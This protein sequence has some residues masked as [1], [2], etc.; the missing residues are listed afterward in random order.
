MELA[1]VIGLEYV[2]GA[3]CCSDDKRMDVVETVM[4]MGV[5]V[6]IRRTVEWCGREIMEEG[7]LKEERQGGVKSNNEKEKSVRSA[8]RSGTMVHL[9]R[10]ANY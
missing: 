2:R 3:V 7:L 6:V 8:A 10:Y 5:M 4:L 9:S 1:C